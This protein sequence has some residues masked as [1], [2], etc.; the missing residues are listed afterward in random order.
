MVKCLGNDTQPP[1]QVSYDDVHRFVVF[2][3][4]QC[5]PLS[6]WLLLTTGKSDVLEPELLKPV[7]ESSDYVSVCNFCSQ[8]N[9]L[10]SVLYS[11][12]HF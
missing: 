4:C 12:S 8:R 3:L 10:T 1:V 11:G 7:L 5:V 2:F 9:F 6:I